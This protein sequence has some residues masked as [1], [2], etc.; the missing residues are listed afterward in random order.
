[1]AALSSS[2][3]ENAPG[4]LGGGGGG[5]VGGEGGGNGGGGGDGQDCNS[6]VLVYTTWLVVQGAGMDPHTATLLLRIRRVSAVMPEA[7]AGGMVLIS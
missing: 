3:T 4:G 7:Q 1:M 5:G 6:A 2:S